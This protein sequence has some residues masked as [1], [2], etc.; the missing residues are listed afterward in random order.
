VAPTV[1]HTFDAQHTDDCCMSPVLPCL[2]SRAH[3]HPRP[4]LIKKPTSLRNDMKS[5]ISELKKSARL[6]SQEAHG[7]AQRDGPSE[8]CHTRQHKLEQHDHSLARDIVITDLQAQI[9]RSIQH[10]GCDSTASS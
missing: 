9:D 3:D 6:R 7:N 10:L 1:F 4:W 2:G 5:I 8:A